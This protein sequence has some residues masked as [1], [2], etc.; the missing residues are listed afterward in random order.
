MTRDATI[1]S[2]I[3]PNINYINGDAA[4]RIRWRDDCWNLINSFKSCLSESYL[5]SKEL[6]LLTFEEYALLDSERKCPSTKV[7]VFQLKYCGV[8]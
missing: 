3:P 7:R 1:P 8:V 6:S 4:F 5:L 2:M